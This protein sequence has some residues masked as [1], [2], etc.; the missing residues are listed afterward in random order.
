MDFLVK[1]WNQ[2][3]IDVDGGRVLAEVINFKR[4]VKRI[5]SSKGFGKKKKK[6]VA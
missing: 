2:L 5:E 3:E 1:K 4:G 6:K